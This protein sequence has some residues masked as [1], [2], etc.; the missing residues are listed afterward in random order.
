MNCFQGAFVKA[1]GRSAGRGIDVQPRPNRKRCEVAMQ[2]RSTSPKLRLLLT[3][4]MCCRPQSK[5]SEQPLQKLHGTGGGTGA[6]RN[7]RAW[8][9]GPA[10]A[11][12]P[13]LTT[14]WRLHR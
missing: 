6:E 4:K 1:E 12:P 7:D 5:V 8:P 3:N 10:S 14:C 11:G 13:S 9:G 2:L